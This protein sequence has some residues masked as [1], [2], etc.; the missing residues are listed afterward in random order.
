MQ[1]SRGSKY[2]PLSSP[3]KPQQEAVDFGEVVLT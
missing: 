1:A 3:V 2:D